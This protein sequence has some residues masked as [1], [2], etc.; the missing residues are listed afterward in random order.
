MW[1]IL[2]RS[3]LIYKFDEHWSVGMLL[4]FKKKRL[5]EKKH[6]CACLKWKRECRDKSCLPAPA[7]TRAVSLPLQRQELSPCPCRDNAE[8]DAHNT[9]FIQ[10]HCR[11]CAACLLISDCRCNAVLHRL[12][13]WK[14]GEMSKC[15]EACTD[16]SYINDFLDRK[17]KH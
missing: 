2:L 15:G 1:S 16:T 4:F 7:E 13:I 8:A 10:N 17:Y 12:V 14:L 3:V 6:C 5:A 9:R 11:V